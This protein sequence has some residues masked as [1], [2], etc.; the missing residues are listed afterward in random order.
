MDAV[1]K[2]VDRSDGVAVLSKARQLWM[3]PVPTRAT[4]EHLSREDRFTPD[5]SQTRRIKVPRMD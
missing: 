1:K 4:E 5:G 2:R 3:V